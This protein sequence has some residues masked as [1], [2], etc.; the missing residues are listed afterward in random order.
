MRV[1]FTSFILIS[2]TSIPSRVVREIRKNQFCNQH[3][4]I[5][6]RTMFSMCEYFIQNKYDNKQIAA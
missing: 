5:I 1:F 6:F 2:S 3:Y 4:N